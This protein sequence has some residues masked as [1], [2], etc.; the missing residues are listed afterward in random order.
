VLRLR[1]DGG[2]CSGFQYKFEVDSK[3]EQ[4]DKAFQKVS[5]LCQAPM[6]SRRETDTALCSRGARAMQL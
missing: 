4:D 6:T 1:V 2:G 5:R 3:K